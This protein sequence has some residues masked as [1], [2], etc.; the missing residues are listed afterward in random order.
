MD[1]LVSIAKE[2]DAKKGFL[3]AKGDKSVHRIRD[4]PERQLD[5]LMD[6]IGNI[7]HDGGKPSV[8]SIAT[9]LS[10]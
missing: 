3:P 9:Q 8:D 4:E 2:A 1:K 10:S 7:R 5:S 6:V